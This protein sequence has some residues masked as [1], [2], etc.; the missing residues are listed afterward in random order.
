MAYTPLYPYQPN[1][2]GNPYGYQ[3]PVTQATPPRQPQI[4][5]GLVMVQSEQ[6]ARSYPVAPGNSIT[7]KD[8]TAPFCYVKTMGFSSLDRPTFERYRLVKEESPQEPAGGPQSGESLTESILQRYATKE[9]LA[10]L[11]EALEAVKAKLAAKPTVKK[12]QEADDE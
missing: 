4:Q 12:K 2:F 6:E 1:Y 3:Q 8:E 10:E 11:R 7:F 9:E 5:Q